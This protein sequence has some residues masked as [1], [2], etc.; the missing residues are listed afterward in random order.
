MD[1]LFFSFL[2]SSR[3]SL[4]LCSYNCS[5]FFIIYFY[6]S[7]SCDDL[8]WYPSDSTA[9]QSVAKAGLIGHANLQPMQK[10]KTRK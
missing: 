9:V 2:F 7:T 10:Q 3:L 6:L 8:F 4:L 5:L 1:F